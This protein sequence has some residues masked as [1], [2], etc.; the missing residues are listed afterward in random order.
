MNE[1]KVLEIVGARVDLDF[2]EGKLPDILNAIEVQR[3]DGT[4]LALEV[5]QHLGENRV[6]AIA[7]DTTD[8]LVRG[9]RAVD[10]GEPISVPVGDAV[11]GRVFDVTG[12]PIDDAGEV[13]VSQRYPI[14]RHPPPP[15]EL[16]T[17]SEMLETG[18]KVIDLI[19]P[20]ARGGKVGFLGGAGVGKTVLVAEL[21]YNIATQ[22]G[23]YSVF[24]GIGERTREGNQ[25]WLE[26]D[27]YGVIDKTAMVF[28]QMNEPPG[29]RLR[30]GLAG[31]SMA[32]YF[33]DEG[34][35]DVLIFIDNVFRF[36][37]AGGEVSALLGRM[38]SAVGYQ[39]T[40]ATEMGELQERITSTQHGSITSFQAVYV[41]ADDYTDPAVVAVF[42]HLDAVTRLERSIQ[43]MG[44]FPAVDPLTSTSRILNPDVIGQEHYD[45]TRQVKAV[46]QDYESLKDIIAILGVDELSDEQ[47]LTVSRARKL[48]KYLTQPMF[49]AQRFTGKPGRYVRIEDTVE[50]CQ[51]ILRGDCDEIPEQALAYIG[52][53]DEAFEQAK[54]EEL[55][56]AAD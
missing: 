50:G 15:E 52:T 1:G 20:V 56:E 3:E 49:V 4:T 17:V 47:R 33:R 51:A 43:Q 41:P 23:G 16:S 36:T 37:L 34:G 42:G 31:L 26:M 24:C 14:H 2:S 13:D 27:E 10:S 30:V 53:I 8:G 5:Q 22:H 39:P 28:G 40:L 18:I 48:E 35:Q 12:Q 25:F 45:T 11:L 19:Q 32:E 55:Q 6:R 7:M 54:S 46:L 9:T 44:R 21:I 38:P 29:A